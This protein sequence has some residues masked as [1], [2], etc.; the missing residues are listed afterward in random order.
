[1]NEDEFETMV[2][3]AADRLSNETTPGGVDKN[4]EFTNRAFDYY[5]ASHG[6]PTTANEA[7]KMFEFAAVLDTTTQFVLGRLPR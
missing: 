7:R 3:S 2:L 4:M 5:V 1:V 6:L